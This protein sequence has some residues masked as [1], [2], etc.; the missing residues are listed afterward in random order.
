MSFLSK[1]CPFQLCLVLCIFHLP[2]FASIIQGLPMED[3][4]YYLQEIINTDHSYSVPVTEDFSLF[5][6][7]PRDEEK[8]PLAEPE[9]P[10]RFI[11]GMTELKSKKSNTKDKSTLKNPPGNFSYFEI[12]DGSQRN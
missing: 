3:Q 12:S 10:P 2:V 5:T 7:Q 6:D 1:K 4:D 8:V 11:P 9:Q